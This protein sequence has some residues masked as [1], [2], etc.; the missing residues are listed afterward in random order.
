MTRS[1]INS[2]TTVAARPV[3]PLKADLQQAW[4]EYAG[5]RVNY[6]AMLLALCSLVMAPPARWSSDRMPLQHHKPPWFPARAKR[7]E[8]S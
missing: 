6:D 7:N 4:L 8:P 3:D 1:S 2:Q 5:W